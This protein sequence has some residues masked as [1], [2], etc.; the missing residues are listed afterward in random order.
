MDVVLAAGAV[1]SL[2]SVVPLGYLAWRSVHEACELRHIQTELAALM[3][4][5]K[6]TGEEVHQVQR[7]IRREQEAT[8]KTIEA[9]KRTVEQ[10]AGQV[11]EAVEQ[12]AGQIVEATSG[13]HDPVL[14]RFLR[15]DRRRLPAEVT[16]AILSFTQDSDA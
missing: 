16:H 2:A 5:M 4:D 9:T 13:E 12:T 14:L 7:E 10:A 8:V 6:R 15:R 1:V 3:R 11:T